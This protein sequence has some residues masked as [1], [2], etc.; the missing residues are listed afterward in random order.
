MKL[1]KQDYRYL[2]QLTQNVT[3]LDQD[4]G[5]LCRSICCQPD[6]KNSL[7]V[8]LYPGE[9]SLFQE[10][11]SWY[12]RENQDP[13]QYGFP[14]NWTDPVYF[15]K[16]QGSCPREARPLACR[17]FPLTPHLLTDGTLLL[18]HETIPLPYK[19]PLLHDK[20]TLRDDF[21]ESVATA[22]QVLIRDPRIYRLIEEDS[23]ERETSW[24]GIPTILWNADKSC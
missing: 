8:Y 12:C 13:Q 24:T 11:S 5:L 14:T 22:W 6:S 19:C 7:G 3:P 20:I 17:F 21:I 18:I 9:E 23:E 2:Y 1:T 10:S 4:C 16:C 15:I